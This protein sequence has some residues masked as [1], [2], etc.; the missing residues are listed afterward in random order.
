MN[1]FRKA[2]ITNPGVER[3]APL[4]SLEDLKGWCL[5]LSENHSIVV[6]RVCL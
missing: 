6:G 3:E 2:N 5:R 4:I 1:D